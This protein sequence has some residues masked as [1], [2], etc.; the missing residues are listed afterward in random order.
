MTV[1]R[2]KPSAPLPSDDVLKFHWFS[3]DPAHIIATNLGVKT[4]DLDREWRRMKIE[5]KLPNQQ[6]RIGV[7]PAIAP[8]V[9]DHLDGRP[10]VGDNDKLLTMLRKQHPEGPRYDIWRRP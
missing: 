2:R 7:G 10:G 4:Y 6:R 1:T 8:P 3:R 9:A 5:G